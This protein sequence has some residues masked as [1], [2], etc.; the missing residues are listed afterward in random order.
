MDLVGTLLGIFQDA[1]ANFPL[2]QLAC[3]VLGCLCRQEAAFSDEFRRAGGVEVI[4]A[5]IKYNPQARLHD[6]SFFTLHV[7][8]CVW[9]AIVGDRRNEAKF[10][11][12]GGLFSLMDVLETAP[13]LLR[14]HIMGC[15]A[16]LVQNKH[17]ANM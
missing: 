11:R 14:R 17:A 12:E 2:R 7:V 15:I 10:L 13:V 1:Q 6:S 4:A 16:D 8:D 3:S 5:E 9:S